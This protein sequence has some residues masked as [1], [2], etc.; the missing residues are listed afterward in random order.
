[1]GYSVIENFAGG[2][3]RSRPIFAGAAGTLWSGVNGHVGR[4]GDFEKRK[5]FVLVSSIPNETTTAK[6]SISASEI[7]GETVISKFV[8]AAADRIGVIVYLN[9]EPTNAVPPSGVRYVVIRHPLEI[10]WDDYALALVGSGAIGDYDVRARKILSFDLFDGKVFAT[11]EF[12]NGDVLP[13]YDGQP[14]YDMVTGVNYIGFDLYPTVALNPIAYFIKQEMLANNKKLPANNVV[15][16]TAGSGGECRVTINGFSTIGTNTVGLRV[17]RYNA[18]GSGETLIGSTYTDGSVTNTVATLTIQFNTEPNLPNLVHGFGAFRYVLKFR[19][20]IGGGSLNVGVATKPL[21]S[22]KYIKT[23]KRKIY[24]VND[25]LLDFTGVDDPSKMDR[26]DDTGAGFINMS[27]QTSGSERLVAI[28]SYQDKLAVF[29]RKNIQIWYMDTNPI[30]NLNTQILNDTGTKAP[31]SVSS[32]GDLDVFYLSET[33]VR[34]I[35]ARDSTNSASVNDVGTPI[36]TF[37]QEFLATLTDEQVTKATSVVEPLDGRYMLAIGNRV[38]V[39]SYFP[40]KRISA[41]SYYELA[42]SVDD[43]FVFGS[44]VYAVSGNNIYIYGGADNKTY[45]NT[46]KVIAQLPF[47]TAG[48]QATYKQIDG[49]DIAAIGTWDFKLLTN[50]ANINEALHCGTIEGF[51]INQPNIGA[52]GHFTH[53]APLLTH[54]GDGYASIS[55]VIVHFEGANDE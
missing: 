11:V 52:S 36:D 26:D 46:Y 28:E 31:N 9:T 21:E 13:Y 2:M 49:V 37:L 4:G 55:S 14:V 45:G 48:K 23:Y 33:G 6:Q 24:M 22:G 18:D 50:P 51:S 15:A 16:A 10:W 8:G 40:S 47:L 30:N 43:F 44:R 54:Q 3:D 41:W 42:F 19:N 17:Y 53:V 39:F 35:R 25:S 38:F 29:S 27:N 1:M 32:Y 7:N 34:S 5:E 12:E 20:V